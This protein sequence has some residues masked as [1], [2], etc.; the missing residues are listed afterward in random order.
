MATFLPIDDLK[1]PPIILKLIYWFSK[2][3]LGIYDRQITNV[4]FLLFRMILS[5]T[6][7][8]KKQESKI[9]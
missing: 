8:S 9:S 3:N 5:K 1:N 6:K 2:G 4:M 7:N